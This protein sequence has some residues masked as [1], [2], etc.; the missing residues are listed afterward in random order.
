VWR[1]LAAGP[2]SRQQE[3]DDVCARDE[4]HAPPAQE[5]EQ[6][7]TRRAKDLAHEPHD[8][9]IA[10]VS[11]G[12]HRL[13]S[14]LTVASCSCARLLEIDAVSSRPTAIIHRTPRFSS[15][16]GDTASS[17]ASRSPPRLGSGN[18]AA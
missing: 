4:E 13:A 6:R 11:G 12:R 9:R 2:R 5:R 10:S 8:S 14:A 16:F 1:F 3:V 17:T 7:V 15:V 18:L